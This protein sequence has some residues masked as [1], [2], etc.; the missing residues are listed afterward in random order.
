MVTFRV[1]AR[2]SGVDILRTFGCGGGGSNGGVGGGV[3]S[4]DRRCCVC[5]GGIQ[6]ARVRRDVGE[7]FGK[8]RRA[9]PAERRA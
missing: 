4:I 8:E 1:P 2:V 3:G 9:L 7:L 5:R 6:G